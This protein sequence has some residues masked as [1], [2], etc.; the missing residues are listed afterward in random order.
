MMNQMN[1]MPLYLFVAK[2]AS[3]KTTIANI[4]EEKHGY[5]D[6]QTYR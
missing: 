1:N 6:E 5:K 4:L 3:G 2:S